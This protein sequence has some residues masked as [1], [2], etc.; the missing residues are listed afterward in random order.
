MIEN[1][2][3]QAESTV[4]D[5]QGLWTNEL[6]MRFVEIAAGDFMMGTSTGA[7]SPDLIDDAYRG[8]GHAHGKPNMRS[9]GEYDEFPQHRVAISQSFRMAT[10]Q[11]TN[12][13][14]EQFDPSHKSKR[15]YLGFSR[16]DDEAVVNVTWHEAMAYCD[17]LSQRDGNRYRLPTEAE[18]EYAARAGTTTPYSTGETLPV[19]YHKNQRVTWYPD[20]TQAPYDVANEIHSLVVGQTPPNPWG[21][22]DV[23]GNVEDWCLDW[24]GPYSSEEQTDPLGYAD[25]DFR[26][27]RGGSHSTETYFLRSANRAGSLPADWSWLTGF[28]VVIGD[29]PS[30]PVQPIQQPTPIHLDV[31]QQPKPLTQIA[32]ATPLFTPPIPYVKIPDGLHGPI[33]SQ[34]NHCPTIIE[35]PNGDL[36]AVWFSCETEAGREM[37]LVGSRLRYGQGEWD[38]PSLFWDAPDRN[39]TAAFFH[40]EGE[41]VHLYGA[42]GVAATWGQMIIYHRQTTDSGATW[43]PTHIVYP[44]HASGQVQPANLPFRTRDGTLIVPGDDNAVNGSRLY[45]SRDNGHTWHVPPGRIL[46]IHAAVAENDQGEIIAFGRMFRPESDLMPVSISTDMGETFTQT[47]TGF[48]SIHGGQRPV[49][50][51]LREGPFLLCSFARSLACTNANGDTF[52]GSGL[53]GALSFDGGHTWPVRRLITI[54]EGHQQLEG[55]AWTG[56]FDMTPANAEPKGY[57]TATQSTDGTIHLISSK[58]HYRFNLAWLETPPAAQKQ[59]VDSGKEVLT[60]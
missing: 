42:L 46:G 59:H 12:A 13:Q 29:L 56:T 7:L 35:C 41:T 20:P 24:Y 6:G 27:I 1:L 36:L 14:Y 33:F 4:T 16:E 26:V 52:T 48:D 57:L 3:N 49:L 15:G 38:E 47:F 53:F 9:T 55:G 19:A 45:V 8:P 2:G 21:L 22:Y 30:A 50:M 44:D 32:A 54:D 18:W 17:W 25:G 28:R 11:V 51:R 5:E 40:R 43:S 34:H 31:H 39:M 58:N 10:H 37:S 23:H 60:P